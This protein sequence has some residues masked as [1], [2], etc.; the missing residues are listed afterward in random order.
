[1]KAPHLV[2][3][4]IREVSGKGGNLTLLGL[5]TAVKVEWLRESFAN[6]F[7]DQV[8]H[9]YDRTHK[10]VAAIRQVRFRD[11]IVA[12]EHQKEVD[13][14]SSGAAL[15]EAHLDGLF[16]LPQFSHDLKQF[17][18]RVNLVAKAN[19]ELEFPI[20]D[21][22]AML[23][24][25]ARAF[26]GMTLAK[27][28]QAAPLKDA[29]Q[30]HLAPEQLGWLDELAPVAI[31]LNTPKPVKLQFQDNNPAEPLKEPELQLKLHE[32]FSITE[33]PRLCEGKVP[34]RLWLCS[35][36]GKRLQSTTNWPEFRAKEYPKLKSNLQKKFP[37]FT[38]L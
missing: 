11:L 20:F 2:V 8:E 28:A 38:W 33:H 19:P 18:A 29:I 10:R 32:C 6:Q 23:K 14:A 1:Q 24:A 3:G 22:G 12:Q 31:T 27:E 21:R 16:E 7:S 36:D 37:G 34:V 17:I 25:L 4:T 9:F 13:P 35:P 30:K 15:A 26:R 5:A